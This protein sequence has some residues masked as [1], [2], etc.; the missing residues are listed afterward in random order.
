M[1]EQSVSL[2][3]E[4]SDPVIDEQATAEPELSTE[5][6]QD[7]EVQGDGKSANSED[8]AEPVDSRIAEK[9]AKDALLEAVEKMKALKA[10]MTVDLSKEYSQLV[11]IIGE[12]HSTPGS[13]RTSSR[14]SSFSTEAGGEPGLV[15]VDDSH[16][17]G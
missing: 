2:T 17:I 9:A 16:P 10:A 8:G 11:E 5:N 6:V 13:S 1:A 15:R 3:P 7:K 4:T 12:F 14:S